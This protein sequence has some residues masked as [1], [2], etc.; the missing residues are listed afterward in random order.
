[1][2]IAQEMGGYTLGGADLLRRA[3]GK[4]NATEMAKQR[5]FVCAGRCRERICGKPRL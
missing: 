4:K 2:Q 3:M 1:M 5:R